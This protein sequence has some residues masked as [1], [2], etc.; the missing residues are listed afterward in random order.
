MEAKATQ[1]KMLKNTLTSCSRD[2]QDQVIKHGL[3]HKK[4]P[5]GR[6]DLR[7][8]ALAAGISSSATSELDKVLQAKE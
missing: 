6:Q 1:L 2:L 3:L 5:V 7:K 8:L 4:K